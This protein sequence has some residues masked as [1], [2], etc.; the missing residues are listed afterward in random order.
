MGSSLAGVT[1][2]AASSPDTSTPG[3][4]DADDLPYS[5]EAAGLKA[6]GKIE[7]G[8]EAPDAGKTITHCFVTTIAT[9]HS[10]ESLI[11]PSLRR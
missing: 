3:L 2:L 9:L 4:S 7:G 1:D 11:K 6:H 10:Q 8:P 5:A